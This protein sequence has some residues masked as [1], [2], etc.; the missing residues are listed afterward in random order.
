MDDLPDLPE[1]LPAITFLRVVALES[2]ELHTELLYSGFTDHQATQIVGQ[3]VSDTLNFQREDVYM[4]EYVSSYD[5]D[6]SDEEDD[7]DYDGD[8]SF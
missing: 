2:K 4:S 8:S 1:S 3:L 7:H 6:D 5:D